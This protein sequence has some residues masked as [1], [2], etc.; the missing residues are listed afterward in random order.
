MLSN[1]Q[2]SLNNS[3][4]IFCDMVNSLKQTGE[5]EINYL[6]ILITTFQGSL[7]PEK[8]PDIDLFAFLLPPLNITFID[9]AINERV[10]L[11]KKNK[12]KEMA[13]FSDD[14]FMMG[15]C[16]LLKL[17]SADKKFESLSWFPS[18]ISYYNSQKQQRK[19]EKGSHGVD[20]LNERQI[21]SYK[22]QFELQY[23]TYTSAA[24]LFNE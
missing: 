13:Y 15:V 11:L 18:V 2:N 19:N 14:G 6:K 12:S 21:T 20:T 1:T 24:I 8:V 5:N 16:Y 17:F 23:F 3:N 22:E 9:N 4:K 10:N 7:S